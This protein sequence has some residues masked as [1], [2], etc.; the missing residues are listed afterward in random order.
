MIVDKMSIYWGR[1]A[2]SSLS[3]LVE[4]FGDK[5]AFPDVPPAP[6]V[7]KCHNENVSEEYEWRERIF[8]Q[9]RVFWIFLSQVI[10]LTQTCKEA[11][12]KTQFWLW[13]GEKKTSLPARR[14]IVRLVRG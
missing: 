13:F 14:L 1:L 6:Q 8:N 12:K 11:L 7:R 4:L 5:I 10:S 9:W 3:E 2:V